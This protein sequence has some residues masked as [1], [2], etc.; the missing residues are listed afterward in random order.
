MFDI[1]PQHDEWR[2]WAMRT[3]TSLYTNV[4]LDHLPFEF[5]AFSLKPNPASSAATP[6]KSAEEMRQWVCDS[7]SQLHAQ[8]A[9]IATHVRAG[10]QDDQ[11]LAL[12]PLQGS[13]YWLP[14]VFGAE[15]EWMPGRM[16]VGHP[17]AF[18]PEALDG[19]RP[20]FA[21][22][23]LYQTALQQMRDFRQGVG[24]RIPISSPDLQSPISVASMIM[25]YTQLI[26][27]MLDAPDTVHAFLRVITD[28]MITACQAFRREMTDFPLSHLYW[29]PHGIFLSDDLQAV[30]NPELYQEFGVPYNE[31]LGQEFGGVATHSCGRIGYNVPAVMSTAGLMHMNTHEP[32]A[33]MAPIVQD[34][35]VVSTSGAFAITSPGHPDCPRSTM[36]PEEVE[37]YWFDDM[38]RLPELSHQRA[39]YL[40]HALLCDRPPE[41]AYR[42]MQMVSKEYAARRVEVTEPASN[43]P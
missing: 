21:A 43:N 31:A 15:T 32:L 38:A 27:A 13:V 37:T 20:D 42:Q 22:S 39:L 1:V 40:C 29:M 6:E 16:P 11:V 9:S 3:L 30:L 23:H 7:D 18:T 33:L 26:Y 2:Q 34:R 14:E 10:F 24:E 17:C 36:T 4:P 8:L 28:A 19:L 25:D 41:D 5:A 12:H 35:A